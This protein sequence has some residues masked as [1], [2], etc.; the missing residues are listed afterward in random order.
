M[1]APLFLLGLAAIAVPLLVHLVHRERRDAV[2]FPSLMFLERTPA[3][4]TD[5]RTVRHPWLFA[6][7]ALVIAALA[8]AFARPVLGR[9]AALSP[10]ELRRREVVVLL[11]RSASMRLGGRWARARI[12]VDSVIGGM[13]RGDRVTIIAFD[14]LAQEVVSSTEGDAV[15]RAVAALTPTDGATRLS[16]AIAMARD[17]VTASEAPRAQVVVISDFQ[18]SGWDLSDDARLPNGTE[19]ATIDVRGEAPVVDRAVRDVTVRPVR[20]AGPAQAT[21]VA[22]VANV[23][24]AVRDARVR[25]EVAGRVVEERMVDVPRDAIASVTFA[26]IALPPDAQP[27]RVVPVGDS[28]GGTDGFHFRL[29]Q[30]R[31][32][33]VLV[34]EGRASPYVARVLSLSDAPRMDVLTRSAE[35]VSAT[36]LVN[37]RVVVL[38]D[39]AFPRG[40][41]AERLMRFVREGGGLV[42]ALGERATAREWPASADAI[43]P[44]TMRPPTRRGDGAGLGEVDT[45]HPALAGSDASA[46]AGLLSVRVDLARAIDTTAGVL[47]RFTDGGAAITEHAIGTGRVLT[48]GSS[49]DGSWN[50]LPRRASFVP[51]MLHWVRHA[52]A[53][54]EPPPAVDVGASVRLADLAGAAGRGVT[55][56]VVTSPSGVRRTVGEAGAPVSI[57]VTEAGMHAVRPG[58][59][60]GARPLLV[61]ANIA[62]AER[63]QATYDPL[64]LVAALTPSGDAAQGRARAARVETPLEREAR[65]STWWYVLCAVVA[66]LVA[67]SLMARR[68]MSPARGTV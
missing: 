67:E 12:A 41:G 40:I 46:G 29:Q 3:R 13:Q 15:R 5:R 23:G 63:E 34:V 25:L 52:A 19:V 11:D 1:L 20:G 49:L 32:L 17:R 38:P 42:V 39:G 14:R 61:A 50:D 65:Q 36:D 21:V 26:P 24:P 62:A 60:P 53:W 47:A 48:F 43:V 58:G 31:P 44:G 6:L 37:R 27:A 51:L 35:R 59:S 30:E 55:R 57:D 54:R 7:R 28:V 56:W 45:R 68:S 66:L 16:P 8:L 18:R 10:G 4:V 22:R 2:P 64:R 33:G 9:R